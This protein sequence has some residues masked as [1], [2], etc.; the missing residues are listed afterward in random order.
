MEYSRSGFAPPQVASRLLS[1]SAWG[2]TGPEGPLEP[3]VRSEIAVT[4]AESEQKELQYEA[5]VGLQPVDGSHLSN[6]QSFRA[7]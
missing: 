5:L 7:H 4:A 3:R 2:R 6:I 1:F